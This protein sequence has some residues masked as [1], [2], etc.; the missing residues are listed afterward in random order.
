MKNTSQID[1]LRLMGKRFK[2]SNQEH[3]DIAAR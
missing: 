3:K 2:L 1:P